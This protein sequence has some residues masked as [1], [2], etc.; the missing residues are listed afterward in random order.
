MNENTEYDD[1]Y[2]FG[3]RSATTDEILEQMVADM[4]VTGKEFDPSR[5]ENFKSSI[6][7]FLQDDGNILKL[8]SCF[9][10]N[11]NAIFDI[12]SNMVWD[13][14]NACAVKKANKTIPE[15]FRTKPWSDRV[16]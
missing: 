16:V 8:F 1:I 3:F 14:C 6:I 11:D 13:Y 5:F 9:K 7:L 2:Q 4:M 15:N 10:K 12:F